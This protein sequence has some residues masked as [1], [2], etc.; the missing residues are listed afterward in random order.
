MIKGNSLQTS[1]VLK[2]SPEALQSREGDQAVRFQGCGIDSILPLR[3]R[4][5]SFLSGL[6]RPFSYLQ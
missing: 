3:F 2:D 5:P 1:G 6:R 4:N